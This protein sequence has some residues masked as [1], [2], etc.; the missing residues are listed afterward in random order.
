MK[1][2][3]LFQIIDDFIENEYRL[4]YIHFQWLQINFT[5]A[6]IIKLKKSFKQDNF[7]NKNFFYLNFYS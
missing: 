4:Q 1:K 6:V 2:W 3:S 5:E 7:L